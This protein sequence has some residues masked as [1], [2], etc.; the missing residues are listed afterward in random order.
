MG[1]SAS[2]EWQQFFSL[3][4]RAS[5][6]AFGDKNMPFQQNLQTLPIALVVR[7]DSMSNDIERAA[8][9]AGQAGNR[10]GRRSQNCVVIRDGSLNNRGPPGA[11]QSPLLPCF[12]ST[13]ML[14]ITMLR[15]AALHMS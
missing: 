1:W 9:A 11:T 8:A 10:V 13:R 12:S 5:Y 14:S 15:S 4:P 2:R 7:N 6:E 3:S